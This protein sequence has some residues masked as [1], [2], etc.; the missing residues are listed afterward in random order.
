M[1]RIS[2]LFVAALLAFVACNKKADDVNVENLSLSR[3]R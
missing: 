1:K 3:T 2:I